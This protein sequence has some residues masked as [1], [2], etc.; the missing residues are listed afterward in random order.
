MDKYAD[1]GWKQDPGG[2]FG[3]GWREILD[4]VFNVRDKT[5]DSNIF[6]TGLLSIFQATKPPEEVIFEGDPWHN[7]VT[8]RF[9][10][11][12]FLT[13]V[14]FEYSRK[15]YRMYPEEKYFLLELQDLKERPYKVNIR[16]KQ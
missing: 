9:T 3:A 2:A 12:V 1:L 4:N 13:T 6:N 15:H 11:D 16:G 14:L 7:P 5:E 8:N 10:M